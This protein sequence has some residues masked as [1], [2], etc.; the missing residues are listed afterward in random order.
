MKKSEINIKT[1]S[2]SENIIFKIADYLEET[3]LDKGFDLSRCAIVFGGRR[4]SLFLK[5]ELS[6]RIGKSYLSPNFFSIDDFLSFIIE[7]KGIYR[8]LSDLDTAFIIYNITKNYAPEMLI[9]REEFSNF[10]PWANE[11]AAFIDELDLEDVSSE[12]LKNVQNFAHIGY[13]V[14]ESINKMLQNIVSIREAYHE[15]LKSKKALSRGLKYL[16]AS[17]HISEVKFSEFDKILFCNLFYL[18]KTEEV[19][20]KELFEKDIA[21]LFFQSD[22]SDWNAFN[23]IENVLNCNI[24]PQEAVKPKYELNLFR[25]FDSHSQVCTVREVIKKV[26]DLNNT[27]ILLSDSNNLVPLLS[28][29]SANVDDYNVSI[30]YPLRRST[31]FNL[32]ISIFKAQFTR[33]NDKYYTKDYLKLLLHPLVKNLSISSTPANTRILVHKIEEILLGIE[34]SKLSKNTFVELKEIESCQELYSITS[35]MLAS[36]GIK[37]SLNNLVDLLKEVH[38]LAFYNW[39]YITD[40]KGFSVALESLL[41]ILVTKGSIDKY[42][43]NSKVIEKIYSIKDELE[44]LEFKDNPFNKYEIFRI[45]EDKLKKLTISFS[46]SPLKGLQI[47]GLFE[48]RALSF[49]NVII[50]DANESVLPKLR[51]YEPLIPRQI[52]VNLG[53]NRLEQEEETQR[54][55]FMRLIG[56]AKNVYCVYDDS[57]QKQRSRFLEEIIWQKEK[58]GIDTKIYSHNKA[59]FNVEVLTKTNNVKKNNETL[60][61]L[62]NFRFSPTSIN[63]YLECPLQF[64][65]RYVLGLEKKEE[66]YD[67]PQANEIG[68]YVHDLLDVTYRKF[69]DKRLAINEH[70]KE[71]FF[72]EFESKFN[73]TIG[74]SIGSDGFMVK[75]ILRVRLERFLYNESNRTVKKV[76]YL[77]NASLIKNMPFR[78]SS[79]Q[80]KC[81]VDRVDIL[82]DDSML[83]LDYKTGSIPKPISKLDKLEALEFSRK[84]I[85]DTIHSFQLPV[86]Y[87]AVKNKHQNTPLNAAFYDIRNPEKFSYFVKPGKNIDTDKAVQICMKALEFILEE[88]LDLSKVFEPD[89]EGQKCLYCPYAGMCQ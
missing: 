76:L 50:M 39:E 82:D 12:S 36:M 74:K 28:E 54:Y 80:F 71:S 57:P 8:N 62:K 44:N 87:Y 53:L 66:V 21:A 38:S 3:F 22:K 68:I 65:Y 78:D 67:E 34:E 20:I 61:F 56:S 79:V 73:E 72:K 31:I 14:P 40:F 11:I 58:E 15:A 86:Y 35:E 30:G 89:R 85:K 26:N 69:L 48:T 47:L 7:K 19:I 55:H 18:H 5:K 84:T 77:E 81:V 33:K 70:F 29:M 49:D 83:V 13:E 59:K 60:E 41:G 16:E 2:F 23:R 6:K 32:F 10:L 17:K 64:Y 52:M 45:F 1:Y 88:I 51:L 9:G 25:G 43:L 42:S 27:V 46:G 63:S 75:E 4:P 37:I 24:K